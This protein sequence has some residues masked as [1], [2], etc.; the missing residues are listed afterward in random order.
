MCE[1]ILGLIGNLTEWVPDC[2]CKVVM[3]N[4]VFY[5]QKMPK[6]TY[7]PELLVGYIIGKVES[8]RAIIHRLSSDRVF[9][10]NELDYMRQDVRDIDQEVHTQSRMCKDERLGP[11]MKEYDQ[12]SEMVK[13]LLEQGLVRANEAGTSHHATTSQAPAVSLNDLAASVSNVLRRPHR[14]AT[15]E[16]LEIYASDNEEPLPLELM[17]T[18]VVTR[19]YSP[20]R[21]DRS[22]DDQ[23]NGAVASVSMSARGSDLRQDLDRRRASINVE[24][25]E[26]RDVSRRSNV[27]GRSNES[28]RPSV[29]VNSGSVRGR[30][31]DARSTVSS[32]SYVSSGQETFSCPVRNRPYP[33]MTRVLPVALSRNDPTIIGRSEVFVHP[34]VHAQICPICPG[35]RHKLYR[36][37]TMLRAGLQ[38]RWF[39]ALRAGVCLNCLIRGHSSFTC[40]NVG[41]CK[42]CQQ[43]H[44]SILCPQNEN[45]R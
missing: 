4:V 40:M 25:R 3:R 1:L 44:N 8:L 7:T 45:N 31:P 16:D 6:C 27:P 13:G 21:F 38:E 24:S 36:C 28:N 39:R 11:K 42:A 15:R 35:G 5:F 20:V 18:M 2:V 17:S 30:S 37:T 19:R 22:P 10:A 33:P 29:A 23:S 26:Q 41:A 34:P 32:M 12:L 9:T 14:E 43:R